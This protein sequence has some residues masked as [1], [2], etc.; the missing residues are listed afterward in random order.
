MRVWNARKVGAKPKMGKYY[1][2]KLACFCQ[3]QQCNMSSSG[4]SCWMCNLNK[5]P[6][7]IALIQKEMGQTTFVTALSAFVTLPFNSKWKTAK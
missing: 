3:Q 5:S 7:N 4:Y 6:L 2:Q 1:S